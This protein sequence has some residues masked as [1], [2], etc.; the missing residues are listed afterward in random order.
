MQNLTVV[1]KIISTF[2]HF[3]NLNN[4]EKIISK[5]LFPGLSHL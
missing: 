5:F 3:K 4:S 1:L 2:F